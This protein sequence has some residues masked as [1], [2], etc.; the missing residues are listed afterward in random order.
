MWYPKQAVAREPSG[1][2]EGSGCTLKIEQCKNSLCKNK[3]QKRV[4][5]K[6]EMTIKILLRAS[7][8]QEM[9]LEPKGFKIPFI[10]SLILAQD[11]RWRRA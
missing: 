8:D 6:S 2:K 7:S 4:L 5:L 3:H 1:S 10:E 11:E 9:I